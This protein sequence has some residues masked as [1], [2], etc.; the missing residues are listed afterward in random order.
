M[1]ALLLSALMPLAAR[2]VLALADQPLSV[3]VC[4]SIGMVRLK[5]DVNNGSEQSQADMP[6]TCVFCLLHQGAA[7]L[8]PS[9][10]TALPAPLYAAMPLAFY[11]TAK[12]AAVWLAALSRGPP[13]QS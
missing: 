6:Q 3:E 2:A 10:V 13:A 1:W 7:G 9:V 11:R 4:T 12:T 8:P 5:S